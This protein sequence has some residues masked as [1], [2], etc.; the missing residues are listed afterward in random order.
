MN[1]SPLLDIPYLI[2]ILP[3]FSV[4]KITYS[5]SQSK[6]IIQLWGEHEDPRLLALIT[7]L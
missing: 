5:E 1:L 2:I 6:V 4:Q 3:S 7:V